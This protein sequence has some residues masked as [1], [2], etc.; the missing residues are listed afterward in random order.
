MATF[1]ALQQELAGLTKMDGVTVVEI[2]ALPEPLA[3]TLRKMMKESLSL[4]ALTAEI[5]LPVDETRQ[6]MEILIEKG[7]VKTE[8][9][10]DQGGQVYKVYFAR[11]RKQKLPANLFDFA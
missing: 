8:D 4:A 9:Q 6:I 10:S 1:E 2:M 11:T 7:Y 5:Q 3:A